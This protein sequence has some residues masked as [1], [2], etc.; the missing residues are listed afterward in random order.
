MREKGPT[1]I[2]YENNFVL[3][4]G[5]NW[6]DLV[7]QKDTVVGEL[8]DRMIAEKRMTGVEVNH[9]KDIYTHTIRSKRYGIDMATFGFENARTVATVSL[10]LKIHDLAEIETRDIPD[11]IKL[12]FDSQQTEN[13]RQQEIKALKKIYDKYLAGSRISWEEVNQL[14][15]DIEER[16]TI[17][18]QIAGL[19]DSYDCLMEK[20]IEIFTGNPKCVDMIELSK[21]KIH[22]FA[23][24]DEIRTHIFL[25]SAFG[26]ANIPSGEELDKLPKITSKDDLQN[27]N[28]EEIL[29]QWPKYFRYGLMASLEH[30]KY[31]LEFTFPGL[32]EPYGEIIKKDI[33]GKQ[34]YN[35]YKT[36]KYKYLC[37]FII[38]EQDQLIKNTYKDRNLDISINYETVQ[39]I[40][41]ERFLQHRYN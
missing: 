32:F 22:D 11:P 41:Y 24:Y 10:I 14:Y 21:R 8:I 40:L 27:P 25:S 16:R 5:D 3:A 23:K 2:P 38:N 4:Q 30:R 9:R 35:I 39:S 6:L 28:I 15:L 1:F 19:A 31:P 26:L 36:Q 7:K 17:P 34:D 29:A 20:S 33:G 12:K 13:L 18:G 37:N